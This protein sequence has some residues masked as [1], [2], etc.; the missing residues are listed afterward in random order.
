MPGIS[1]SFILFE[2]QAGRKVLSSEKKEEKTSTNHEQTIKAVC[3]ALCNYLVLP[4]PNTF[5][6]FGTD[7]QTDRQTDR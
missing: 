3:L 1:T 4:W 2:Y 7:K 6:K 5:G